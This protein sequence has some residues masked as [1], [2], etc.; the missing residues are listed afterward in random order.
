M[1][2][3]GLGRG[4]QWPILSYFGATSTLEPPMR[5]RVDELYHDSTAVT[6]AALRAHGYGNLPGWLNGA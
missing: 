6:A 5:Q 3:S 1:L 2:S 4:A